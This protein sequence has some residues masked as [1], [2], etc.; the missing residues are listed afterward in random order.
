LADV[1]LNES[2]S[3]EARRGDGKITF[4]VSMEEKYTNAVDQS[5]WALLNYY[6]KA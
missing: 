1:E 4:I 5:L 3:H 6:I 2:L